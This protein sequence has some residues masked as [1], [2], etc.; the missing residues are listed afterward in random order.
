MKI[1]QI[2]NKLYMIQSYS[3]FSSL[4]HS[5]SLFNFQFFRNP[6][7]GV[8][9]LTPLRFYNHVHASHGRPLERFRLTVLEKIKTSSRIMHIF[10]YCFQFDNEESDHLH[11]NRAP[12]RHQIYRLKDIAELL[13]PIMIRE[14]IRKFFWPLSR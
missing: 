7:R 8:P 10:L 2:Y 1:G 13:L 3:Y 9:P 5:F 12:A 6:L 11:S 4:I 14:P